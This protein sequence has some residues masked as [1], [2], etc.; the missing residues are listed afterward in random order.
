LA[1]VK[2]D[3]RH[4]AVEAARV[5]IG[6]KFETR[7]HETRPETKRA[8]EIVGRQDAMIDARYC[9][10]EISFHCAWLPLRNFLPGYYKPSS[11]KSIERQIR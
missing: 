7:P 5:E 11:Q 9:E 4:F 8:A 10:Q 1:T 3:H 2:N 6:Q